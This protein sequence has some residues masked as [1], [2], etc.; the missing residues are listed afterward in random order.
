M[1]SP[2]HAEE[3]AR[4]RASYPRWR[5]DVAPGGYTA[6]KYSPDGQVVIEATS[7]ADLENKLR[8][9]PTGGKPRQD[10]GE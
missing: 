3:L 1:P 9:K 5:I 10:S 7:L 8:P 2:S 6:R 4:I